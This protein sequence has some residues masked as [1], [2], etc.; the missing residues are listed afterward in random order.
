VWMEKMPQ[1]RKAWVKA[2]IE[3]GTGGVHATADSFI[4]TIKGKL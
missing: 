3:D 4:L 1:Q 2:S